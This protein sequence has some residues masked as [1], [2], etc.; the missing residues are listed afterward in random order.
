MF[1]NSFPQYSAFWITAKIRI[2]LFKF[3]KLT[4]TTMLVIYEFMN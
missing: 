4:P 2:A 1:W 3:C